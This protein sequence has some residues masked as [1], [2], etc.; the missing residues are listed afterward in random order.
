MKAYFNIKPRKTEKQI[1]TNF[2]K[3]VTLENAI[4]TEEEFYTTLTKAKTIQKEVRKIPIKKII[5]DIDLA[6]KELLKR[7]SK[8]RNLILP[9]LAVITGF[10]KEMVKDSFD[11]TFRIIT[12]DSLLK[13]LQNE[14][15]NPEYL[16]GFRRKINSKDL[17]YAQGKSPILHIV[18]GNILGPQITSLVYGLM[19]KSINIV[20]EAQDTKLFTIAFAKALKEIN[21]T[22]AKAII[23]LSWKGG[24]DPIESK[25]I[26]KSKSVIVYGSD[27]T[28]ESISNRV[29]PKTKILDYGHKISF[30]IIT[31]KAL[32]YKRIVDLAKRS[33]R[34]IATYDQQGC[35]STQSIFIE[36]GGECSPECFVKELETQLEL[37]TAELPP[38]KLTENEKVEIHKFREENRFNSDV[39]ISNNNTNWSIAIK[40]DENISLVGSC[41]NRAIIINKVDSISTVLKEAGRYKDFLQT[42]GFAGKHEELMKIAK[43]L[44][45]LGVDRICSLGK[46]PFPNLLWHH[47][48]KKNILELLNWTDIES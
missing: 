24:I 43:K 1:Y 28:I 30:S 40:N 32:T 26:K 9:K 12:K 48:G 2:D 33:A 18:S 20:K 41:L 19:T 11:G 10:S 6:C 35:L 34:D 22:L 44:N 4:I 3:E 16:D 5:E 15:Q 45:H 39:F 42:V 29:N 7:D 36:N 25:I 47:D 38:G 21:P 31:K 46:M 13:I 37:M 23:I 27:K 17:T 8:I 14:I